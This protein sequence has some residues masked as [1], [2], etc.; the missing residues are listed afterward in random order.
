MGRQFFGDRERPRLGGGVAALSIPW[1]GAVGCGDGRRDRRGLMAPD[2]AAPDSPAEC[3]H[4][5][6]RR[7]V[8]GY[9]PAPFRQ[10]RCRTSSACDGDLVSL[11]VA[12]RIGCPGTCLEA[13]KG[14][15]RAS[16]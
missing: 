14:G 15:T 12:P 13:P 4:A 5:F 16:S 9:R 3:A 8:M 11:S 10:G 1:L 7:P 2:D 6:L